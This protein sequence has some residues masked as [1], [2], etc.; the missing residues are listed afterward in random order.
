MA[1]LFTASCVL[2]HPLDDGSWLLARSPQRANVSLTWMPDYLTSTPVWSRSDSNSNSKSFKLLSHR[3]DAHV[4][5]GRGQTDRCMLK[6]G[7]NFR[8][9]NSTRSFVV[10]V[11]VKSLILIQNSFVR[12]CWFSSYLTHI[13]LSC[14]KLLSLFRRASYI[15]A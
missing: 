5:P 15:V 11:L 2:A 1:I 12:W 9:Q 13:I 3:V 7:W 14:V 6:S 8:A 4:R 10:D